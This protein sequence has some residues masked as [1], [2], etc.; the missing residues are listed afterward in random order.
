[1]LMCRIMTFTSTGNYNYVNNNLIFY[2]FFPHY[3][4][5]GAELSWLVASKGHSHSL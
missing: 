2:I 5:N 3:E 1:M 4:N